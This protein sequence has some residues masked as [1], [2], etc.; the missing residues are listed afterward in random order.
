[1]PDTWR[2][3]S[4]KS[5]LEG[6]SWQWMLEQ[7]VEERSSSPHAAAGTGFHKAMED[8]ELSGRTLELG[9]LKDIAA[10]A[11][12]EECKGVPMAQ[13]FEHEMDPELV[14]ELA[15]ESARVWWQEPARSNDG[16]IGTLREVQLEREHVASECHITAEYAGSDIPLSGTIDWVGKQGSKHYIVDFKTASSFRKWTYDQAPGIEEAM[17]RYLAY[18]KF[19][20]SSVAFEWHVVSAKEGKARL[21]SGSNNGKKLLEVLDTAILDANVLHKYNA[22]RPRPDWNLCQ[23]KWCAF[24]EGCQVDGTLSPT[25]IPASMASHADF[26][27]FRIHGAGGVE[28]NMP[29]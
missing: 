7:S 23:R 13:W 8:W 28:P 4:L 15:A 12:F 14:M 21:I 16:E 1:M 25:R 2:K 6:C 11:A 26:S 10:K 19:D 9:Q 18:S 27:P 22:Y 5:M 24:Y 3:S 20:I 29:R 17:Y